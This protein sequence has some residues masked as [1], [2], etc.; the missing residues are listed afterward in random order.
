MECI[1]KPSRHLSGRTMKSQNTL[2]TSFILKS[3]KG[4]IYIGSDSGY[5]SHFIAIGEK[6]GPFDL[7]ILENG[8]YNDHSWHIHMTPAETRTSG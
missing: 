6:Y 7:V 3:L 5:D 4:T 1:A 8:Q 2:W